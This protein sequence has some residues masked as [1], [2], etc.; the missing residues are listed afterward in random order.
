MMNE[1]VINKFMEQP[2]LAHQILGSSFEQFIRFFHWYMYHNEFIFK[3]FHLLIIHKLEDIVFGRN[4]KRNLLINIAPR[5]GKLL[6]DDTPILTR[7]GWKN[8]GDLKVGDYVIGIDGKFKKVLAVSPK[9]PA[10]CC[11]EFSDGDKIYCH[12]NHEWVIDSCPSKKQIIRE[13]K[14]FN[15]VK[16]Y[17]GPKENIRGHRYLYQLP[18]F[19]GIMGETK[20]L[21]IHPYSLGVWLGDGTNTKPCITGDKRDFS[22]IDKMVSEGYNN[23]K[24][25]IHKGT[26]V[27]SYYFDNLRK[28]LN[29]VGMCFYHKTI[30][31]FIPDIYFSASEE[32]RLNLLAGLLDT[33]GYLSKKENR[34]HFTTAEEPLRDSFIKLVSTF[35]WRV[36]VIKQEP[37]LSSSGIM[38]KH[39][40]WIISFNP[41][42]YIPCQLERKQLKTFSKKRKIAFKSVTVG[43]FG[44]IGNCIEVEDGIYLAGYKLKP[45]HNSSIMKY[46]CAWSY[47]INPQ[48]NCI[49]TSYSDDLVSNFSKDIREIVESPAFKA[50][51]GIKLNKAKTGADYWATE[52][53]G[54]FRAAPLGGSLTGFGYGISGD[55][56]G[57]CCF[58]YNEVVWTEIGKIRI[59]EIVNK[60]LDVKVLSYNLKEK[61]FEYKKID[62]YVKNGE[63]DILKIGLS[64]GSCIQCT[65]DHK[66]WTENRGYVEAQDLT[67]NDIL[68]SASNSFDLLKSKPNFGHNLFSGVFSI[69][70]KPHFFFGKLSSFLR[71]IVNTICKAFKRFT[72]LNANNSGI[73]NTKSSGYLSNRPFIT[74]NS[75]NIFSCE[76]SSGKNK[77]TKFNSIPHIFR[78]CSISKVFKSVIKRIAVKMSDFHTT[79]HRSN[80]SL[81]NGSMRK[82][83][84]PFSV[85]I[86]GCIKVALLGL[87]K[88]KDFSLNLHHST[89]SFI[90]NLVGFA[91]QS[92]KVGNGI[93]PSSGYCSPLFIRKI[94]HNKF[95]FC[96]S[97]RDNHNIVVG[98][99]QGLL[100]SN[101]LVDD[102]LKASNVKSQAEM[103]NTI[104]YY[105]NTLKSRANNQARSPMICIMQR[106]AIEDLS[107]YIMEN[108]AEDWDIVKIPALDEEK[109]EALWPE[110]FSKEDL[111]KLK[112]LSP[113]V[114]YGQYQQ[115]PIV[116]GG[117][118]YKTE[119]F[120]FYNP[121]EHYD[122]QM[123]F[124]TADTAQKKGE[125]NDF[126]VF[127]LWAKTFDNKLHLID[128]V[129][130]KFDAQELREQVKLFWRKS[131]SRTDC[132]APYGFYIEDKSSGIGVIQ[133]IKKT[134]PIPVIP[135]Q[136]N[137]HKDEKGQW[138]SM[139]KFSRAMTAIPYIANGWVYLPFNEKD[140]IS[141]EL[142]A[143]AAAFKAD[144][145]AKHDDMCFVGETL[146]STTKGNKRLDQITKKDKVITPFGIGKILGISKREADVI[147]NIGLTGTPE[148]KILCCHDYMFDKLKN[149]VYDN[150]SKLNLTELLKW[151]RQSLY[152][153]MAENIIVANRKDISQLHTITK[154]GKVA[155]GFIEMFGNFIRAKKYLKAI[156]FTT[157]MGIGSIMILRTL[158]VYHL[159]N[160]IN[161]ILTKSEKFGKDQICKKQES[162]VE[163]NVRSGIIQK[164]QRNGTQ[165]TRKNILKKFLSLLNVKSVEK[166]LI[167]STINEDKTSVTSAE[168]ENCIGSLDKR[169][170]IVYNL[171]IDKGCY[172]ANGILVSNCDAMNDAID[173]A[174]GATGLSSIFI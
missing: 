83:V 144:L 153:L 69:K 147:S 65:P 113:F 50:F 143:E 119:W 7:D 51:S 64:N 98:K 29:K 126:T 36:N 67:K 22:I 48:S 79:W 161:S 109:G 171:K 168:I 152:Y 45:T 133:E 96:L 19:N 13:T 14:W 62:H 148:H 116:I 110:K 66:V 38:G 55:V 41:D 104:D 91:S 40:Y 28:D 105:L 76:F 111:L 124:I 9:A 52:Q 88:F 56:Y 170:K 173:I 26:G 2:V 43:D 167:H 3:P 140:R 130:G 121:T 125:G 115:E 100:V 155:E 11:V 101:C 114:Y 49:Y 162:V 136:R 27:Y 44:K 4:K 71:I 118:V 33:D 150:T 58:P 47:L 159:R 131:Q 85:Y 149:M 54:G 97:V 164:K 165:N 117:S 42:R 172:Y 57:G 5:F 107:G 123:S 92:T 94:R 93:M 70:N 77:C 89:I 108:E 132:V 106:L 158:F 82:N 59:G 156:T 61:K 141:S 122:Y 99:S 73:A 12:E 87:N 60:K 32:Q 23:H 35:G 134:D 139:D 16:M 30:R 127:Q 174:F 20:L 90:K 34:Y 138:V 103:Q 80:K 157:K 146:I 95:S 53:G 112:K 72:L 160:I 63:S 1:E 120:R 166:H 74:A 46:F 128:M 75:D 15:T 78:L 10:N 137:R 86:S 24:I 84:F 154:T 25:Y 21:P 8:H 6:A 17:T 145:S 102:P 151:K 31:K 169:K 163:K 37:R 142:L 68:L 135:I 129:R 81:E 18:S 39:P